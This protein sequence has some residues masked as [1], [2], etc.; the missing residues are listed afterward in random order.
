VALAVRLQDID[1]RARVPDITFFNGMLLPHG[2][3]RVAIGC[4]PARDAG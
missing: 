3:G 2:R 4:P 1:N